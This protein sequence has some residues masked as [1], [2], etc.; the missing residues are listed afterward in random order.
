MTVGRKTWSRSLLAVL[1]LA[2]AVAVMV[3]GCGNNYKSQYIDAVSQFESQVSKDDAKLS[4]LAAKNDV[5]GLIG[6][7]RDRSKVVEDTFNKV[8]ALTPPADLRKLHALTLYYL[9][10]IEDQ[11]AAQNDLY[12]AIIKG[13]P[14]DDLKKMVENTANRVKAVG[15]DLG[16]EVQKQGI[17][18]KAPSTK[19]PTGSQP[20]APQSSQPGSQ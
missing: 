8:I 15:I 13:T 16:V 17:N 9:I 20:E 1:A 5:E 4:D 14:T 12:E 19:Q 7:N 11:I 3:T 6:L 18:I 2:L 10:A